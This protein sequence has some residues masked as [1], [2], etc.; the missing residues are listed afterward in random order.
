MCENTS[1]GKDVGN[2]SFA[3]TITG[4]QKFRGFRLTLLR[5]YARIL[6]VVIT[7]R[8]LQLCAYGWLSLSRL[9]V[10]LRRY[11]LPVDC[12]EGA[13]EGGAAKRGKPQVCPGGASPARSEATQREGAARPL[14]IGVN[15]R[16]ARYS[17]LAGAGFAVLGNTSAK[18]VIPRLRGHFLIIGD[19]V[20]SLPR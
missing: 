4:R 15:K 7:W 6:A 11:P 9:P 10:P 8:E 19:D 1:I 17:P 3:P 5:I 18:R 2:C 16:V 13:R 14:R 20:S 12:A